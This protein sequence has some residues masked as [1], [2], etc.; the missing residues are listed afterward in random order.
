MDD[1]GLAIEAPTNSRTGQPLSGRVGAAIGEDAEWVTAQSCIDRA[2][3]PSLSCKAAE[4]TNVGNFVDA[5]HVK[6]EAHVVVTEAASI[7]KIGMRKCRAANRIVIADLR[8]VS[9]STSVRGI[10]IETLAPGEVVFRI[11][12]VP[13]ALI[14]RHLHAVVLGS[15]L[16]RCRNEVA[17][18]RKGI[19]HWI[20]K[21][22]G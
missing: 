17:N 14:V 6:V 12:P 2:Q 3:L 10:E 15:C 20:D 11:K 22:A 19:R 4:R 21:L 7:L 9:L 13:A 18:Q 8:V 5:G 16:V 1:D